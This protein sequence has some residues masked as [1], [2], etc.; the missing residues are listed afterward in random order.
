MII[1]LFSFCFSPDHDD[2][3]ALSTSVARS[4]YQPGPGLGLACVSEETE[5]MS[6]DTSCDTLDTGVMSSCDTPTPGAGTVYG[7]RNP[8]GNQS[9]ADLITQAITSCPDKKL[10]LSQI[11]DWMVANVSYFT[12]RQSNSKSAGWKVI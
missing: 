12:D 4:H 7:R 10:T 8:W 1:E 6:S 11:Y 2:L 5:T 9:Y 3:S